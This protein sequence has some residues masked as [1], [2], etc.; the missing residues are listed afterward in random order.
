MVPSGRIGI[1][2]K[3]HRG[4]VGG[5]WE[6]IGRLQY[7]FLIQEGLQPEQFLLDIG[8][9]SLRAGTH[10]IPYLDKE[11]YMGVEKLELL[12]ERGID[13]ELGHDI[14]IAKKPQFVI[15]R[16]FDFTSINH[17]PDYS[18]AHS[19]FTHL[20]S[21]LI[22]NCLKNLR[23]IIRDDGKFYATFFNDSSYK[24]VKGSNDQ[25]N[26]YYSVD[27]MREMG[28]KQSWKTEYIGDWGHPRDQKMVCYFPDL[29]V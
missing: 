21:Q 13:K 11:H 28:H 10:L 6:E 22:E 20:P 5:K 18:I 15:T 23:Q 19:V 27:R 4:Y 26:Y 16:D 1:I 14:F 3:G 12:V 17:P 29:E 8:C 7:D 9:G 24:N 2:L 25:D